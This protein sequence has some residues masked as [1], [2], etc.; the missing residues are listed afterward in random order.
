MLS[1]VN[2]ILIDWS[3]FSGGINYLADAMHAVEIGDVFGSLWSKILIEDLN[4]DPSDIHV[5]GHS[6]GAHMVGHIARGIE[7]HG[8]R[9]KI[10]RASGTY[11]RSLGPTNI[12]I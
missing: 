8:G 10:A 6:L 7:L 11:L 12:F 5:L 1:N 3:E 4:I 9:G 2:V